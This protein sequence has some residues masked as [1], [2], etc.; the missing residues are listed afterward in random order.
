MKQIQMVTLTKYQDTTNYKLI[1]EGIY[2]TLFSNELVL[3][4]Y[5]V[6]TLSFELE[7]ELGEWDDRQSPLED[8]LD[9]YYGFISAVIQDDL[10]NPVLIIEISTAEGLADIKQFK[11]LVGKHV[12]NQTIIT[13]QTEYS[14]LIIE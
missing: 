5:Y 8:L 4:G 3:K 7:K 2:Q 9:Q 1:E 6:I 14:E 11:A 12:Y 10:A 13:D